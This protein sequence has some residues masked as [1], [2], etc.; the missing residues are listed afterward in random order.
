[1]IFRLIVA[2]VGILPLGCYTL[3]HSRALAVELQH[4]HRALLHNT[5]P[6]VDLEEQWSLH[7]GSQSESVRIC[8][9]EGIALTSSA[10]QL[11]AV[12]YANALLRPFSGSITFKLLFFSV[13]LDCLTASFLLQRSC[14]HISAIRGCIT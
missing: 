5:A 6:W 11:E 9:V 13:A 7:L 3:T 2:V 12:S 1:M 8:P 10:V 14:I 4:I